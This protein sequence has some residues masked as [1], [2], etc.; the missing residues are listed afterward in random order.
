MSSSHPGLPMIAVSQLQPQE[1]DSGSGLVTRVNGTGCRTV[2]GQET[3]D[4]GDP[5]F[6]ATPI[7]SAPRDVNHR[8]HQLKMGKKPQTYIKYVHSILEVMPDHLW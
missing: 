2:A 4:L 3:D 8:F 7:K 1:I 6:K 5:P